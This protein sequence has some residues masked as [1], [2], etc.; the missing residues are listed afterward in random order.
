M[1]TLLCCSPL[2]R[3][4][5]RSTE[6]RSALTLPVAPRFGDHR[7]IAAAAFRSVA[8]RILC[9]AAHK[10]CMNRFVRRGG[11]GK[12]RSRF[13]ARVR[14]ESSTPALAAENLVP[15]A[16]SEVRDELQDMNTFS[17]TI[18][19]GVA[20]VSA[21]NGCRW[22]GLEDRDHGVR[23]SRSVKLHSWASPTLAQRKARMFARHNAR[24]TRG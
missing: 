17:D 18:D 4:G 22:C 12:G 13:A 10:V 24:T 11:N 8:P 16:V 9:R 20:R 7:V 5:P 19:A 21:P 6:R 2:A 1:A 23:Y 14:Q 3:A 15:E